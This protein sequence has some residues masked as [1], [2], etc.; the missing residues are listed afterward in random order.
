MTTTP[1]SQS[2]SSESDE[3]TTQRG[4]V[5]SRST[6]AFCSSWQIVTMG[7]EQPHVQTSWRRE[8]LHALPM[9]A[10]NVLIFSEQLPTQIKPSCAFFRFDIRYQQEKQDYEKRVQERIGSDRFASRHAQTVNWA[11]KTKEVSSV[12]NDTRVGL[13]LDVYPPP[14]P[15]SQTRIHHLLPSP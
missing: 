1:T 12:R 15:L 13:F 9:I 2:V 3:Q 8:T 5:S 10:R 6:A 14:S 11:L 7:P 4:L